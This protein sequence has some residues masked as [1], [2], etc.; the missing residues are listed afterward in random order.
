MKAWSGSAWVTAY[1]TGG[2]SALIATN[3]LSDLT[4]VTTAR[5][6]LGGTTVGIG[7]YTATD[8]PTAR[9]TLGS[10][11][12]GDSIF[13]SAS[14]SAVRSTLG[15]VIG[16]DVQAYDAN[17]AKLNVVQ[18]YSKAQRGTAVSLTSSSGSIAVDAS[19]ANNFTHTLTENTQLANPTNLVVGQ[20]GV[21][22]F[23]QHA[24]SPKTLTFAGYWK[25]PGG[26]APSLTTTNSAVDVVVYYVES[27]TRISYRM[28]NDVK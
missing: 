18:A 20:S 17:T 6:N 26:T 9:Q 12:V 25:T 14:T 19:L 15:L 4:N 16:T 5:Q 22:V 1:N 28:L 27:A 24:S 21:I 13:T 10:T 23:T 2:G 3:N 11:A 8:A 7:V